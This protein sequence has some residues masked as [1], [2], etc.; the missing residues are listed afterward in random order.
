MIARSATLGGFSA[1]SRASYLALIAASK[2]TAM[3]AGMEEGLAQRSASA[4]AEALAAVLAEA[5]SRSADPN[6]APRRV[7]TRA[8]FRVS[9]ARQTRPLQIGTIAGA[10]LQYIVVFA[11]YSS[12]VRQVLNHGEE[13]VR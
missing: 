10:G 13:F 8:G 3:R 1:A 12:Y 2:R 6:E 7:A 4:A 9:T 11:V 5:G